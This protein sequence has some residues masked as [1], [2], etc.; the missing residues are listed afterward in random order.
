[1]MHQAMHA[2]TNFW[3]WTFIVISILYL[4]YILLQPIIITYPKHLALHV[5]P[6]VSS[7]HF[8]SVQFSSVQ[9]NSIQIQ[10]PFHS[11]P[12]HSIPFNSIQFNSIQFNS[13]QSHMYLFPSISY[14]T[15]APFPLSN[16][17][18]SW[19]C[20][21]DHSYLRMDYSTLACSYSGGSNR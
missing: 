18:C 19:T 9:F 1:M 15:S 13:I 2:E 6:N 14:F 20:I 7:F 16:L 8:I 11:I 5:L 4:W 21:V 17:W 10:I 3:H 12:F